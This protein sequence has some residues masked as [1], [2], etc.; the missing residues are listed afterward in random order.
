M[1]LSRNTNGYNF[2]QIKNA[3]DL[4]WLPAPYDSWDVRSVDP[5]AIS[6]RSSSSFASLPAYALNALLQMAAGD[7]MGVIKLGS[8]D[9]VAEYA[10]NNGT[11]MIV[12]ATNR[13]ILEA[14]IW[15]PASGSVNA[16]S[17]ITKNAEID[18]TVFMAVYFCIMADLNDQLN[19]QNCTN[20]TELN[21][22]LEAYTADGILNE[23]RSRKACDDLYNALAYQGEGWCV[24]VGLSLGNCTLLAAETISS[25]AFSSGRLVYGV[26]PTLKP[27]QDEEGE[28]IT[29][30]EAMEDALVHEYVK[31]L[32]WTPDEEML[33]PSFPDY[34]PVPPE[35]WSMICRFLISRK[36]RVPMVNFGWRGITGYGKSTGVE[37]MACILHTPLLRQTCHTGMERGDFL[38]EFVPN[39]SGP[40]VKELPDLGLILNAPDMAYQ[41]ITGEEKPDATSDEVFALYTKAVAEKAAAESGKSHFKMVE[42]PFIRALEHGYICEIQEFSRIRDSGVLVGLNEFDRPGSVIPRVDGSLVR[43]H[44]NAICV[45]TDNIGYVSCRPVDPSVTRRVAFFKDSNSMT[46]EK[47]VSRVKYNTGAGDKL[48]DKLYE[49]WV[50]IADYC[51]RNDI[52]EGP[53]DITGLERTVFLAQYERGTAL[54]NI[55]RDCIVAK[56]TS[57]PDSQKKI[58]DQCVTPKLSE[59]ANKT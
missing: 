43:R 13:P 18:V 27:L 56:A 58:M 29:V 6:S 32:S 15:N 39:N 59:L 20:S 26:A 45:W 9:Y 48:I 24:N 31:Q 1:A 44:K 19:A 57:D 22:I 51:K 55:V 40:E 35:A 47:V 42:A 23:M 2:F 38:C 21:A 53:V 11:V 5:T 14:C 30:K 28:T 16:I 46:K 41:M 33:I 34:F 3:F 50:A 37:V 52:D 17:G 54:K 10:L 12:H 36:H 4:S 49:L 8:C 25:L 7:K